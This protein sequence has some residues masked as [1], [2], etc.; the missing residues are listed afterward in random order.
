MLHADEG[1]SLT[2]LLVVLFV[3]SVLLLIA[4]ASYVPASA[5]ANAAACRHNQGALEK[6]A[7]VMTCSVGVSS[8]TQLV[9]LAQYVT[10]FETVSRCPK[11]GSELLFD[12]DTM[13]VSCPNHQ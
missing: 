12:P 3:I 1:F 5:A 9:D 10:D 2:E 11:D 8:P 6:A 7:S 4:I 13:D